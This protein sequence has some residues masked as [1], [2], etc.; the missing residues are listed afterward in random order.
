MKNH[1]NIRSIPA[2]TLAVVVLFAGCGDATESTLPAVGAAV[3]GNFT[4]DR[5]YNETARFQSLKPDVVTRDRHHNETARLQALE[6]SNVPEYGTAQRLVA[7]AI[8]AQLYSRQNTAP[9]V[10]TVGTAQRL[11]AESIEAELEARRGVW[12]ATKT[13]VASVGPVLRPV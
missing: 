1:R 7:E 3:P 10:S 13:P 11:I 2:A 4:S 9:R 12:S 8:D 6:P 5:H